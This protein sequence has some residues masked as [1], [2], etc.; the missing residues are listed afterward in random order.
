MTSGGIEEYRHRP[1]ASDCCGMR[2]KAAL[3]AGVVLGAVGLPLLFAAAAI[4]SVVVAA[5]EYAVSGLMIIGSFLMV[6]SS[7]GAIGGVLAAWFLTT[8]S[9]GSVEPGLSGGAGSCA[10][11]TASGVSRALCNPTVAEAD[12]G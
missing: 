12:R 7:F 4:A 1:R 10:D 6:V 5:P 3:V 9:R 8:E 2:R 11:R